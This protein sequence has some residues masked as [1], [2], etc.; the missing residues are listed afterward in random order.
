MSQHR[1]VN[2]MKAMS[3]RGWRTEEPGDE[4]L[5]PLER[6]VL[7]RLATDRL[8][9]VGLSVEELADEASLPLRDIMRLIEVTRDPR[10]RVEL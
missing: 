8:A 5:G 10:P 6:T 7:L 9:A 4:N 1:Y 2:A 3:S